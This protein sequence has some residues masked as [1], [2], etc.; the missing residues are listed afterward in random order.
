M[1]S[2]LDRKVKLFDIKHSQNLL[3][4][5][6]DSMVNYN[7]VKSSQKSLKIQSL[8]IPDLPVYNAKFIQNG[9]K[10]IDNEIDKMREAVCKKDGIVPAEE[11]NNF[12]Y[13]I[14]NCMTR[15]MIQ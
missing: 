9:H 12:N 10:R 2:G 15:T 4:I 11:K 3:E 8:F 13:F 1:T 5:P 7:N 14:N 6:T